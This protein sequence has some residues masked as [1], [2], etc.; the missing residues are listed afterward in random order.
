MKKII[1]FVLLLI[2]GCSTIINGTTQEIKINDGCNVVNN[3]NA[4]Q[5]KEGFITVKRSKKDLKII[6]NDVEKVYK[7][8]LTKEALTSITFIDFGLID[9][10]TNAAWGYDVD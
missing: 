6:C 2:N 9:F 5:I 8:S 1:I 7:A 4:S 10:L 3:E